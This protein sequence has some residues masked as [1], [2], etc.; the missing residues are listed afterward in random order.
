MG[1]YEDQQKHKIP[2][3][4]KMQK[5]SLGSDS[6]FLGGESKVRLPHRVSAAPPIPKPAPVSLGEG[7]GGL[8]R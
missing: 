8:V 1:L 7:K 4:P 6:S 5:I 3:F 2:A